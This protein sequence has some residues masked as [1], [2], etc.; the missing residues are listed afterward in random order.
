MILEH[1]LPQGSK[2]YFDTSA[3]LK[4][5]IESCAINAFYEN[6]YKEIV[7][8]T[9]TFLEHQDDILNRGLVRLN[10]E[11]NHQIGLRY[12]T[13]FEA[14]RIVTKH[15][16]HT[17]EHK[18]WFYIQPVFSYPTTEIHQIGAEHLG[19][20][21]LAPV[22][23]LGVHILQ[24][25]GLKPYLQI[26]N[27]KIPLLCAKHSGVDIEVFASQDVGKLLQMEG[28]V[29]DLVHIKTKED[30]QNAINNAPVF[31]RGELERLLECASYC[32]Y[33]KSIFSPL[34]S[35]PTSYYKDLFF[36]MFLG[37]A[38]LLQGGKYIVGDQ[39]SC[40]FAIYTDEVV[41]CLI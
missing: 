1:E 21:S 37:N 3:K 41:E 35:S 12:D 32:E 8:P 10:S 2:L 26:S 13:T 19:G 18:K 22:M 31:L 25:L 29:A 27:M 36:R 5:D 6:D 7:T 20:E 28:Y 17:S 33:E 23:C 38:T 4:R 14:M 34:A 40:G 9:F 16:A 15:I 30:V 24:E 11:S 39:S